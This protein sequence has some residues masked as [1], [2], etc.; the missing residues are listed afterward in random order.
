M[1]KCKKTKKTLM[2]E[3]CYDYAKSK[4]D[5]NT[6]IFY[7]NTDIVHVRTEDIYKDISDYD[8]I[9]FDTSIFK[10]HRLF[11]LMKDELDGLI[12]KEFVGLRTKIKIYLKVNNDEDKK[13]QGIELYKEKLI[14]KIIKAV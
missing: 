1:R 2:Y 10:L 14:K 8:E 6:K 13:A 3:F 11:V 9:R 7:M 4:Y 12:T 5:E